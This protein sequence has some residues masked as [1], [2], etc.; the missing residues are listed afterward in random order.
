MT[1]APW[2]A[3]RQAARLPGP[4]CHGVLTL[5]PA[6]HAR[7][8]VHKRPRLPRLL[9]AASQT[10]RQCGR[11]NLGGQRGGIHVLQTWEQTLGAHVPVHCLVPGGARGEHGTRGVPTPP[12]C[13]F[14]VHA[15]S[16][17][18]RGTCLDALHSRTTMGP[19][20]VPEATEPRATPEGFR[21]CIAQLSTKAWIVSAKQSMGGPGPVLDSRNRYPHR[22]AL[23]THRLVDVQDGPVRFPSRHQRQGHR[24]Q[25][26][27]REAHACI[28]RLLWPGVPQ[29]LPRMRPMGC[30]ANRC[31]ARAL[32]QGHQ[33]RNQPPDPPARPVKRVAE[34]L[35][36]WTGTDSTR[37]PAC[38]QEP[39]LP[40]HPS[41]PP[42]WDAS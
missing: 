36:Q 6:L 25:T 31:Q 32:R 28:R 5:P 7:V 38:G 19:V 35:W 3:D 37:G 34:W 29:R 2:V 14:P 9:Q 15:L 22:V 26:R 8:L 41:L 40:R 30:L 23:A 18:F 17:G 1:K 16:T 27:T 4:Y 39:L 24:V 33:L 10:L 20:V 21:R 11:Q 13:F 12:R 42:M